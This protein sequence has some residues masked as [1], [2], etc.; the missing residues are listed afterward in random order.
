MRTTAAGSCLRLPPGI[1]CVASDQE[2]AVRC[3]A[4]AIM[5]AGADARFVVDTLFPLLDGTRREADLVAALP[6][7]APADLT[8]LLAALRAHGLLLDGPPPDRAPPA[9]TERRARLGYP[10]ML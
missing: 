10:M 9:A 2:I 4:G 7:V 5:L 8:G 3:D 6:Q 1:L